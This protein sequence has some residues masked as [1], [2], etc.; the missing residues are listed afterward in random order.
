M[1]TIRWDCRSDCSLRKENMP[2]SEEYAWYFIS[3]S[4]HYV[5]DNILCMSLFNVSL[6]CLWM[7]PIVDGNMLVC[8]LYSSNYVL[9]SSVYL[10]IFLFVCGCGSFSQIQNQLGGWIMLLRRYGQ[11]AWNISLPSSFF[12][13]SYHG[14]WTNSSP[15]LL[16]GQY[17]YESF[18]I[19]Y[20]IICEA[21]VV[22]AI[23]LPLCGEL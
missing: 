6:V 4:L 1:H 12:C 18:C 9:L 11:Y 19:C 15:G 2:T 3:W 16:Y 22:V 14:S 23:H 21:T 17:S 20:A 13:Q 5:Y 8:I 7:V 10:F